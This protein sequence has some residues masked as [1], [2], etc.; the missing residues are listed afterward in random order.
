[1]T[2]RDG[3]VWSAWWEQ[4]PG[5]RAWFA[6]IDAVPWA[7]GPLLNR[8]PEQGIGGGRWYPTLVTLPQGSVFALCGHPIIWEFTGSSLDQ[9]KPNVD[10]RHNNTK[11]EILDVDLT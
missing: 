3:T 1:M 2:G 7:N 11:P 4:V 10:A 9:E 8:D 6:I 5:W